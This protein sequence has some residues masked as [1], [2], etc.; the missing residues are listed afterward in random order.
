MI[1]DK[2][3]ENIFFK[4]FIN[5][6]LVILLIL[7]VFLGGIFLGR[8]SG[9]STN[10]NFVSGSVT[11]QNMRSGFL[12]K[13]ANFDL[14]WQTWDIIKKNYVHQPVSETELLY[15]AMAGSVASLGDPHSVFFDPETT[16]KFT[17]ELKGNFDGIGAEV[18]IKNNV[19]TIIASLPGS[20]AEKAGLKSG[21]KILAIDGEDTTA[22]SLD[23][24]VNKIRG[25]RGTDVVLTINREGWDK[26]KEIKLTRQTIKIQSVT[27]KMLD[28]DIAQ[29]DLRYF[30]E[31]T[32]AEF[33]KI[34]NQIIAKNPKGIVLDL[35]NN[36]GGFLDT[37]VDV[38][39]EWVDKGVVVYEKSADGKLKAN[40]ANGKA[41]FKD[42]PT[43]VLINGGSASGSEIVAGALKDYKLATL[44]GEKTFG[45]G[46]VQT[47][48]PLDDG[49]S[50]KLT[51]ALWLT[52]NENTIDGQGIEPDIQIKLTDQDFNEN[53][54]PQL[55]KAVQI[56]TSKNANK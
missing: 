37:A 22:M 12:S 36:P 33:S 56:L 19:I 2:M 54:D 21:D 30:N 38:T 13:N 48:F 28:N 53:K 20:P 42:F 39:S 46:S 35:R 32:S 14:F 26:P 43:V 15:G 9:V 41:L 47:L 11:N 18:A 40:D 29:I 5:Y 50:I 45:K 34:V 3:R 51:I 8:Q 16:Q 4:K 27:W 44:V 10:Q 52:P 7:F 1:W 49:S 31:D 25:Q 55:D 24:A 23:Y 6:Y 17:N